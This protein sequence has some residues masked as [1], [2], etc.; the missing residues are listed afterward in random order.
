VIRSS[1]LVL[2]ITAAGAALAQQ[3]WHGPYV[4]EGQ[5]APPQQQPAI[6]K[7]QP[8]PPAPSAPQGPREPDRFLRDTPHVWLSQMV[9]RKFQDPKY[10]AALSSRGQI[11]DSFHMP[12]ERWLRKARD[13][14]AR[15]RRAPEG[16]RVLVIPRAKLAP[17]LD[18]RIYVEEWAGALRLP[19]EPAGSAAVLLL[20]HG[21]RL[22]LAAHAFA[23]K[24]E[25]GYDQFRFWFHIGLSSYLRN[26][27]VFLAGK[28]WLAQL[29]DVGFA[30]DNEAT[31]EAPPA[32]KLT[33]KT[34]WNIFERS[35]GAS[36]M[37]GY[38]QYELAVDM[39]EVGLFPGVS[40]PAFFE[41]EGDPVLDAAGKF[42]ARTEV[43]RAGSAAA[44]IWFLISP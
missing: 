39:A 29:R 37:E 31:L 10:A 8:A 36:R 35:R 40:F 4:P 32:A 43:G 6:S 17:T 11:P 19:L 44:P 12:E 41:I 16:V 25:A 7:P 26:E 27:R 13:E 42:K 22:Y 5:T 18:G 1:A 23:D 9:W 24:T 38:R 20:A 14:I 28:G 34:D 2:L 21:G 30:P 33:Y 3:T 15:A